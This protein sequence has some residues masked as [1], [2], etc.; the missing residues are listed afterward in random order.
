MGRRS[1]PS[2]LEEWPAQRQFPTTCPSLGHTDD[3]R[4]CSPHL[5]L[6]AA[7]CW[8][9]SGRTRLSPWRKDRED[10]ELSGGMLSVSRLAWGEMR[11]K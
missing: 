8:P 3:A 11:L 2:H 10:S 1:E 6:P 4:Q 7:G 9:P 5:W